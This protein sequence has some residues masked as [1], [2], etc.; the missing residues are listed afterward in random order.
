VVRCAL[1]TAVVPGKKRR[2]PG[3]SNLFLYV[4][5]V[6]VWGTTWIAIEFQIGDVAPEVSVFYRY[7]FAT[8]LLFSWC[9]IQGRQLRFGARA[10]GRFILLGL[11]LFS[12]NYIVTYHAQLYITSALTAIVFSTMLWM[13]IINSRLF[14]GKR[15]DRGTITGSILGIIGIMFL[16]WPEVEK[17]SL[18][19][20]TIYGAG[21]AFLGALIASLG[22]MV[23]QGAQKE[24]LPIVQSNAW[25]MFYGA[26]LTGAIA[27]G[28]GQEFYF[29]WS[30]EYAISL[31]YLTIFGSIIGFGSYLT[32]LGRIGADKAGYAMV[33]FP[34]VAI[35][36]S[37]FFGEVSLNGQIIVGVSFVLL[38]NV[39]TLRS[40][41]SGNG[42]TDKEV[43]DRQSLRYFFRRQRQP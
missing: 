8:V 13:N 32:L 25:G 22:N 15:I 18:A 20:A 27:F 34:V 6:L 28:Q 42:G 24:G 7:L 17:L 3:M 11:L 36:V 30:A 31:V 2:N 21:L 33:M 41:S 35:V 14:F 12:V 16:F 4:V 43:V 29:D 37:I 10:H 23:S 9:R 40:R 1:L 26:I 39:L 5:T 19:D 38:G